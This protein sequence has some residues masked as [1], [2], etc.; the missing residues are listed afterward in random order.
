MKNSFTFITTCYASRQQIRGSKHTISHKITKHSTSDCTLSRCSSRRKS[1]PAHL[2]VVG[3]SRFESFDI[4]QPNLPTPFCSA[5]GVY[6][7]LCG[8]FNCIS[9]HKFSRQLSAFSL[10]SSGLIS[11]L[12]ILSTIYLFLKVSQKFSIRDGLFVWLLFSS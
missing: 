4:N 5:L 12:L 10:C 11:A 6:F 1:S 9:S 2:H 7:C 3:I 8:S